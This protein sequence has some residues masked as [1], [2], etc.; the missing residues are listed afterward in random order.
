M[1]ILT[2]TFPDTA[3]RII[4]LHDDMLARDGVVLGR[5]AGCGIRLDDS[6]ISRSHARLM[7][8]GGKLLLVDHGSTC[9]TFVGELQLAREVPF[10]VNESHVISIGPF[11]LSVKN[12]DEEADMM[13]MTAMSEPSP[14]IYMPALGTGTRVWAGGEVRV[15]VARII[16]ETHDVRTFLFAA[17][18][19]VVFSY[20]PG[21]FMSL[22]VVIDGQ[23]VYRSYTISSSPSRPHLI[24]VTVKRVAAHDGHPAGQV[25]NWLHDH[26]KE[27]DKLTVNGPF[28]DFSCHTHSAQRLCLVSA[29]SGITPMLSMVRW[30]TDSAAAVDIVFVHSA[31][32]PADLIARSELESLARSNPR[33]S[34]IFTVSRT[35]PR[36]AWS[37]FVGRLDVALLKSQ[38][39]DLRLRRVFIC[40]P[41]GFM[42]SLKK[43]LQ[44]DGFPMDRHHEESFGDPAG[45][46]PSINPTDKHS[47]RSERRATG[48]RSALVERGDRGPR[49]ERSGTGPATGTAPQSSPTQFGLKAIIKG[50]TSRSPATE[51]LTPNNP[52]S[53]PHSQSIRQS[54]NQLAYPSTSPASGGPS[55]VLRKSGQTISVPAGTNILAAAT[56]A[57]ISLPAGC[58]MGMCGACKQMLCA[59]EIDKDGYHD[60]VLSAADRKAGCIL[61]CIA[62]PVGRIEIDA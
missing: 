41:H 61:V 53:Q 26:L 50:L 58:R 4:E 28:G 1:L 13:E 42:S 11:L 35:E 55:V 30:L 5:A 45:E 22:Q 16:D 10:E 39:P 12:V 43:Q 52:A 60:G 62:K 8:V 21:Q 33:L 34:L 14:L 32:T 20:R 37:G 7:R 19:P 40:G 23:T 47:V 18:E 57:G 46:S 49:S 59:G 27:G 6:Q 54:G 24:G 9:G 38:V 25:S 51:A 17:V 56:A 2:I 36:S 44:A 15:R 3:P 29:G 48:E 31:R